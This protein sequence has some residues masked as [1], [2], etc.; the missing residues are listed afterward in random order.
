M[1]DFESGTHEVARQVSVL[2]VEQTCDEA[3]VALAEAAACLDFL[4]EIP[5]NDDDANRAVVDAQV[6]IARV[7]AAIATLRKIGDD[8]ATRPTV[9]PGRVA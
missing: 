9:R 7:T 2:E 3:D 6:A 4:A 5:S 8:R 1:V